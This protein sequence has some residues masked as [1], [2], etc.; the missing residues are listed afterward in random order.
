MQHIIDLRAPEDYKKSHREGA[1]NLSLFDLLAYVKEHVK[2]G[3]EIGLY[4][5]HGNRS[6]HGVLLLEEAGYQAQN[7][8]GYETSHK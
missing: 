1:V 8:G 2:E 7:L 6:G 4:C 5:Y 3:D